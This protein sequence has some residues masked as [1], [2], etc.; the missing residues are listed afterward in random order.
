MKDLYLQNGFL[1]VEKI[2]S[3]NQPFNFVVGGRG[4]GKTY[5]FL[6]YVIEKNK[7]F[8]YLRRTQTQSDIIS[9]DGFS[10]FKS[11]NRDKGWKIKSFPI[12]KYTSAFFNCEEDE[13]GKLIPAGNVLGYSCALSTFSSLRGF[14]A[15]D[16]EFIIYDEFIPERT[17][18]VMKNEATAFFN[19][20]ETI[21]RNREMQSG[22][23]LRAF[24]LANSN[25]VANPIFSELNLIDLVLKQIEDG[26]ELYLNKKKG[27]LIITLMKSPI[28][29]L[30]S[31]HVLYKL[32]RD[33][34]FYRMSIGNAFSENIPSIIKSENLIEYIP[35][36]AVGEI[37]FYKHKTERKFYCTTHKSGS[38]QT[39]T[40]SESDLKRFR[41]RYRYLWE[42]YISNTLIFETYQAEIIFLK[43]FN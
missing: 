11:L 13:K 30:K 17:E 40:S 2:V 23:I 10:P 24:C 8:I 33:S 21:A 19:A 39:F 34:S 31:E 42:T 37:C 14:D 36:C 22:E 25:D 16:V 38:P 26:K 28:S 20:Y 41:Q 29:Q 5:G 18:K 15:S 1:N 35:F 7:K 43:Y 3:Y 4:T 6:E 32:T 12:S 9:K 27:L